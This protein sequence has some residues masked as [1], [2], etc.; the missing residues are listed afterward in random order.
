LK[1]KPKVRSN[2][3]NPGKAMQKQKISLD[4]RIASSK[5]AGWGWDGLKDE[6]KL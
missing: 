2:A 5:Q 3:S 1:D 4:G 6:I